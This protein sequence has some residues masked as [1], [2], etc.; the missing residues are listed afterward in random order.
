MYVDLQK[1]ALCER[2]SIPEEM[3]N[4]Q[5]DRVTY[6]ANI[7]QYLSL[8]TQCLSNE[9]V[10]RVAILVGMETMHLTNRIS[11]LSSW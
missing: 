8:A 6:A 2:A 4:N 9:P 7:S 3:L 5:V 10:K 11:Y 1:W